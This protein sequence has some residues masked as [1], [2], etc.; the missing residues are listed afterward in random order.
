[1]CGLVISSGREKGIRGAE[2]ISISSQGPCT[3]EYFG[4]NLPAAF[5]VNG[6]ASASDR[7]V[8][9]GGFGPRRLPDRP[10]HVT[11]TRPQ[12]P[13]VKAL[14][15]CAAYIGTQ[16][17]CTSPALHLN[18]PLMQTYHGTIVGRSQSANGPSAM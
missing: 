8:R 10:H 18:S 15:A 14:H 3:V 12:P 11:C 5:R 6:R 7:G 17:P 4:I 1:M 9:G 13:L 2:E 16:M